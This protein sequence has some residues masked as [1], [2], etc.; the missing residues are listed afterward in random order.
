MLYEPGI[1]RQRR[2]AARSVHV[3]RG[4]TLICE[5]LSEIDAA[6]DRIGALQRRPRHA[7]VWC[8]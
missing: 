1:F 2:K 7:R 8:A 3:F 6:M 5:R 4:L